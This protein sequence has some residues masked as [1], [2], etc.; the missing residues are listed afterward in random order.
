MI[1]WNLDVVPE[2]VAR[3]DVKENVVPVAA[4]GYME[5]VKVQ[6]RW[7]VEAVLQR[8]VES[9]AW[10]GLATRAGPENVPL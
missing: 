8:Q 3:R 2:V 6:V 5:P 9:V 4:R 7:G 1:R 10:P